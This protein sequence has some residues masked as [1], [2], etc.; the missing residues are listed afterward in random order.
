MH[1]ESL[2][3]PL[4]S[5]NFYY[6]RDCTEAFTSIGIGFSWYYGASSIYDLITSLV[7]SGSQREIGS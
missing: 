7:S 1:N 2:V 4:C 5:Q 6:L 3:L